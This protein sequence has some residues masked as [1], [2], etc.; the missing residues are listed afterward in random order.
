M[1]KHELNKTGER[2]AEKF[3]NGKCRRAIGCHAIYDSMSVNWRAAPFPLLQLVYP[4]IHRKL[5]KTALL[6]VS[7]PVAA[8]F[9]CLRTCPAVLSVLD[10]RDSCRFFSESRAP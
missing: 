4:V 1:I 7:W 3:L 8:R 6:P 2:S 10:V 5:P 9:L